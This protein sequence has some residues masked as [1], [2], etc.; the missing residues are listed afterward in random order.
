[1]PAPAALAP[2]PTPRRVCLSSEPSPRSWCLS[3]AIP[4]PASIILADRRRPAVA[5]GAEELA[6]ERPALDE[7]LLQRRLDVGPGDGVRLAPGDGVGA[8]LD[9]DLG[10]PAH[11]LL[12][13]RGADV[14]RVLDGPA[15]DVVGDGS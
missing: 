4:R 7:Q 12:D 10:G 9:R 15:D 11:Q 2:P 5:V 1:M 13:E 14:G 6:V 8:A 3:A